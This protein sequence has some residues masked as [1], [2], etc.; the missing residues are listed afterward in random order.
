MPKPMAA[1]TRK[2]RAAASS[3]C[4]TPFTAS[5]NRCRMPAQRSFK[6]SPAG[7]STTLRVVR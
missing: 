2:T 6:S 4:A 7:V 1:L 3:R 5:S